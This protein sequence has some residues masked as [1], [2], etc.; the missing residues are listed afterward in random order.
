MR[1]WAGLSSGLQQLGP[2]E[3]LERLG[4]DHSRGN[5]CDGQL[6]QRGERQNWVL[7]F[8]KPSLF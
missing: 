7:W 8:F 2:M 4:L 1:K 3:V 6:G 5:H